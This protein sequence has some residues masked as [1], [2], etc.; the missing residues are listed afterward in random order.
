MSVTRHRLFWPFAIWAALLLSNVVLN[1][2]FFKIGVLHGHLYGNLVDVLLNGAPLVL[3]ALGMTVVIATGGIDLSVGSLAAISGAVACLR[4]SHLHDQNSAGG[5]LLAIGVALVIAMLLG[6][7]NGFLV[8][9][10][11]IQPIVATLI[12]LVSG[13]GLAQLITNGAIVTVNSSPYKVIGS[14]YW[15]GLPAD[16][17]ISLGM[18]VVASVV[19][20]RSALGLLIESVGGNA[21]ASRLAGVRSRRIIWLAYIFSG[22]C[23]GI[24]GLMISANISG[25]D[26]NNA[27]LFFELDAILAVVIGGTSLLGGRFSLGATVIGALVIQTLET[28]I[29]FHGVKPEEI[30]L[31]KAVVVTFIFLLQSPAFRSKVFG[32]RIRGKPPGEPSGDLPG[33]LPGVGATA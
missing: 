26:G 8:A 21:V 13:R 11:G 1:V 2:K 9:V 22:L 4:I 31:V 14:G 3:I 20:R 5:V 33:D 29:L 24:A 12:L 7:L 28:T 23:A 25:A 19:I 27:G 6:A 16:I 32:W 10:V 17:F 15:F 30:R 18:F